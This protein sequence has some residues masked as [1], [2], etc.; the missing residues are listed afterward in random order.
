MGKTP[1]FEPA[2]RDAQQMLI[3]RINRAEH[4]G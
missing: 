4:D 2:E 3:A 1:M